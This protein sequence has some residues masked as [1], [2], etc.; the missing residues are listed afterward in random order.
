M[1][2]L[3]PVLVSGMDALTT[4]AISHPPGEKHQIPLSHHGSF[5][6]LAYGPVE[7]SLIGP[8]FNHA[9]NKRVTGEPPNGK[10]AIS[11]T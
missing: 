7:W 4:T 5:A 8:T 6:T 9:T 11:R 2:R 3:M 1:L 10:E